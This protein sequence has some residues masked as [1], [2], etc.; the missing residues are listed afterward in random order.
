MEIDDGTYIVCASSGFDKP[1]GEMINHI[2]DSLKFH[3]P[4]S[5][6]GGDG[7]EEDDEEEEDWDEDEGD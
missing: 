3:D 2:I 1:G 6:E 7:K 5:S 4:E